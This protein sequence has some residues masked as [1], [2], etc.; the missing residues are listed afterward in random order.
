MGAHQRNKGAR[1]ERAVA[2]WLRVLA[3]EFHRQT[4]EPQQGNVGDIKS[5]KWPLSIQAKHQKQPSPWRALAEAEEAARVEEIPI[6]MIRRHGGEDMVAMRPE[7]FMRIVTTLDALCT[8][9]AMTPLEAIG[10]FAVY[11]HGWEV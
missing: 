7:A 10:S 9:D 6:A 2:R 5:S 3:G 11:G 1:F 8:R 4:D